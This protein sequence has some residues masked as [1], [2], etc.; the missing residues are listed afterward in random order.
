LTDLSDAI[1]PQNNKNLIIL[2]DIHS[3]NIFSSNGFNK[4]FLGVCF[5]EMGMAAMQWHPFD[6]RFLT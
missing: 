5:S 2:R 6:K 4:L 1:H 3:R